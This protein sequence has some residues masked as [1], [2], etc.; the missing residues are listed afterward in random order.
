[1]LVV[2]ESA[3]H[4]SRVPG[5]WPGTFLA[6]YFGLPDDVLAERAD[7]F[8]PV[9]EPVALLWRRSVLDVRV[10]EDLGQRTPPLVLA[11]DVRRD[12]VDVTRL[13][14]EVPKEVS[15]CHP[16]RLYPR[17]MRKL[18][19]AGRFAERELHG[20]D[21]AGTDERILIWIERREGGA[22]GVGRAI[23]PQHR[24]TDEP[25]ADDYVFE[26]F[27]LDDALQRANEILEDDLSV[28]EGDGRSE[29]VRPFTRKELLRPL[30][31]WFFGHGPR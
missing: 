18:S 30:E 1:M 31:R 17:P 11:D 20:V 29:H 4:F 2:A 8:G 24:S 28:S 13:A 15:E 27:E 23:N 19:T 25:R 10:V 7:H 6:L 3:K 22:W 16:R 21:E 5:P 26:G 12:P 14:E 9:E